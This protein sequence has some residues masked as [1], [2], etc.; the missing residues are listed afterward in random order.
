LPD[1]ISVGLIGCGGMGRRHLRG[2][3]NLAASSFSTVDLVAVCDVNQ[4]NAALVADEAADLLGRRPRI[5]ASVDA[6]AEDLGSDLQATSITT[7]AGS[8]HTVAVACLERGLHLLCEK[9]LALT[10]RGCQLI[11]DAAQRANRIVSVGENYRRDPINRLA[12]AL[13]DAGAI[14]TP[15]LMIETNIAG[16]DAIAITPWRH[17]KQ[18]GTIVVDAGIHYADILRYYLGEVGTIYGEVRLHEKVRYNTGSAGP[19][20]FYAR[21]SAQFPDHVEPTGEDAL[22]AHLTF[23]NGAVGQWIDDHAGHGQPTRA[24]RV[25][26]SRAS[27]DCPG[28]RNGRPIALHLDDG[29]IINDQRILDYAQGYQLDPLAAE[30][31]GDERAWTYQLEFND[32][33]ARLLALEYYELAVCA[34]SGAQPE[35][36]AREGLADLALTYAP[37]ESSR[38]GRPVS[39]LD[40]MTGQA[41]SYQGEIDELLGL[42][43]RQAISHPT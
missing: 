35:V 1:R 14:G 12:R 40:V 19:G 13:I 26:G 22:Y 28:D 24:R 9:P 36:T 20:G 2:L 21:W 4:D 8:H 25:F 17:M 38:L 32:T 30:L 41:D 18:A 37:F 39:L 29:Q 23:E 10:V 15:R 42:A 27:L 43:A 3:A 33:D 34:A 11:I 7:D 16:K 6:M 31:F 5:Y